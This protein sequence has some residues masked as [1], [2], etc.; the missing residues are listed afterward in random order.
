MS[1]KRL[2]DGDKMLE[3]VDG[4]IGSPY[5][6]EKIILLYYHIKEGRF[7]IPSNQGEAE[8]LR[9]SL[10][11]VFNLLEEHQPDWYLGMH[12]KHMKAALSSHTEDTAIHDAEESNWN[13]IKQAAR[14]AGMLI[15]D[16]GIQ[17]K[18][19][20]FYINNGGMTFGQA[21]GKQMAVHF[22][23]NLLGFTIPGITDGGKADE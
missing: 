18:M 16:T 6:H 9:E 5:D 22:M 17:E 7:D 12:Y 4:I 8:R 10:T 20:T 15:K 3:A 11:E 13:M 1:N 21:E 2:I 14:E 23:C 19:K